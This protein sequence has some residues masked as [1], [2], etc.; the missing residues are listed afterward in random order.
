MICFFKNYYFLFLTFLWISCTPV[1]EKKSDTPTSGIITVSADE[2]FY[3]IVK[4]EVGAFENKYSNASIKVQ[5]NPENESIM[6]F[7]NNNAEMIFISRDLT[8]KEKEFIKSKN[9]TI[10][11]NKIATD[12]IAFIVNKEYPDSLI[13]TNQL[14]DIFSGRIKKWNQLASNLPDKEIE[15]VVDKSNSG[16]LNFLNGKMKLERNTIKIYAAG[17]NSKVMD[18]VKNNKMSIGII[19]VNWISDDDDP[20]LASKLQSL[21]VLAL[22]DGDEKDPAKFYQPVQANLDIYPLTRTLYVINKN[23]KAGL[24]AGFASYMLS[25]AGQ[26]IILKSGLLPAIMPGRE[27]EIKRN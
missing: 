16:N 6:A 7:L 11:I 5:Y 4:A 10:R 12:G 1:Q 21:K 8:K 13:T 15:I 18:H 22:A 3:P 23:T 17:S 27:I 2:S 26:R 20:E 19:G 9:I 25:D 14:K 24:G